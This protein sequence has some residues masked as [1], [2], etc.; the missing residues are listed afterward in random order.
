[1]IE[2]EDTV[3][4]FIPYA[5]VMFLFHDLLSGERGGFRYMCVVVAPAPHIE[6]GIGGMIGAV[7]CFLP[8]SLVPGLLV[9]NQIHPLFN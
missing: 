1:M 4:V 7:S 3:I 8:I 5:V 9:P 2:V 6:G